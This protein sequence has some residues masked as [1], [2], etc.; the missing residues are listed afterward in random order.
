MPGIE[1]YSKALRLLLLLLEEKEC[2][3]DHFT[4]EVC[5]S[6]VPVGYLKL[7][8]RNSFQ[9]HLGTI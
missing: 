5:G 8:T 6:A 4:F 3:F 7:G 1:R 2:A 9:S